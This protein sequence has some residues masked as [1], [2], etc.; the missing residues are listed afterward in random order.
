MPRHDY[1]CDRCGHLV[2]DLHVALTNLSN[3]MTCPHCETGVLRRQPC[4]PSFAITGFNA[5][6]GYSK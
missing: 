4:A 6:N 3:P 1:Q 5:K 2:T